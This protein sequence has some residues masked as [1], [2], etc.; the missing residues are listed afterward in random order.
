MLKLFLNEY[1]NNLIY[2]NLNLFNKQKSYVDNSVNNG[3]NFYFCQIKIIL[4][5][6]LNKYIRFFTIYPQI[7]LFSYFII[8]SHCFKY[9]PGVF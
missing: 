5:K 3:Y 8:F 9:N 1:L 2:Y 7:K 6:S 4:L